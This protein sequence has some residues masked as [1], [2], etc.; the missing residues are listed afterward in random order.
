MLNRP[1]VIKRRRQVTRL[2]VLLNNGR[3]TDKEF[4]GAFDLISSVD[5]Q[6]LEVARLAIDEFSKRKFKRYKRFT[7][8]EFIEYLNKLH[9][10]WVKE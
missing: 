5:Q 9:E 7:K 10:Q 3:I 4:E 2:A 8:E 6:N 1:Q